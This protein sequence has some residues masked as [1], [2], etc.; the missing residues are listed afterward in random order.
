[1]NGIKGIIFDMDNTLLRSKI[2]F[3]AMKQ[4]TF[5]FIASR[6]ILPHNLD[7]SLHTTSTI[8]EEAVKTNKMTDDLLEEMWLI[9][10]KHEMIGMLD[11]DLEPGVKEALEKLEGKYRMVVVTNNTIE[12]AEVALQDHHILTYFDCLVGREMVK[13]LKPSPDGFLYILNRYKDILVEEWIS[14]GD[15]WID[16]KASARAGIPFISYQGDTRL[17][18]ER[19]VYPASEIVDIRE[20]LVLLNGLN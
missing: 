10:K 3:Q 9:P 2:D 14:V 17:M 11:A 8:V 15:S 12:A 1:M 18:N 16:G 7:L 20:L 19:E 13:S 4:D 5:H 6:G